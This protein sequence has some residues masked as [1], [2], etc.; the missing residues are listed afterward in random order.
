MDLQTVDTAIFHSIN[1]G[2]GVPWLDGVMLFLTDR[3]TWI[4]VAVVAIGFG[5]FRGNRRLTLQALLVMGLAVVISDVITY[6][7]LKPG[8]A[9]PRPCHTYEDVRLVKGCGGDYGLPSNHSANGAAVATAGMLIF[10]WRKAWWLMPFAGVVGFT[11]IYLGVHYPGDVLLGFAVGAVFG[12]TGYLL[13][14][15]LLKLFQPKV[16][17]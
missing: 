9:R 10:G 3:W 8:I 15:V 5:L 6:R 16:L 11:R 12:L 1:Q 14:L 7:V 13:G 17:A 2:F 4:A